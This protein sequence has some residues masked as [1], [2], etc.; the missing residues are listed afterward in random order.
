MINPQELRIGN[1]ISNKK[2]ILFKVLAED[3]ET[4]NNFPN[5]YKNRRGIRN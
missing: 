1:Y 4:I 3:F 2:D 5:N